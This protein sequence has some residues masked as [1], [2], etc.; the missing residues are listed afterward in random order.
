M[1]TPTAKRQAV[2]HACVVHGVSKRRACR[3]LGVNRS[4]VRYRSRRASDDAARLRIR[5]L[6]AQRRRFGYRRLHVLLGR[7]GWRMNR[8]CFRR[9]Y[10]EEKL[11]VRR[12]SGRK[13]ALACVHRWRC[14]MHPTSD[15]RWNS[16]PTALQTGGGF[17]FW[18]SST[19]SR[20]RAW[21]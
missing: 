20:V 10:R 12:R 14:P 19:T 2:A 7:E 15:G 6:A 9:L 11:Q 8:K 21:R 4:S 1:V 16:H 18:R 17:A 5:E 13:R 3:I